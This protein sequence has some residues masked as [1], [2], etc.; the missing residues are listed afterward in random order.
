LYCLLFE[1]AAETRVSRL[2]D[3]LGNSRAIIRLG[4]E[5]TVKEQVGQFRQPH[6]KI[7]PTYLRARLYLGATIL[8]S[9]GVQL[10]VET[11]SNTKTVH[12]GFMVSQVQ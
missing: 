6:A 3:P 11:R 12:S 5:R 4:F 1:P 10:I 9:R 8:H 2:R 7:T